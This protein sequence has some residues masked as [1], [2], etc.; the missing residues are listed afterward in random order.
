MTIK[1]NTAVIG[2]IMNGFIFFLF[3]VFYLFAIL[4]VHFFALVFIKIFYKYCKVHTS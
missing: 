2:W 1:K 4:I 3:F